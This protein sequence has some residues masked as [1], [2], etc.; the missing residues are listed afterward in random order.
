MYD[1]YIP[2]K[3]HQKL[4]IQSIFPKRKQF[5]KIECSSPETTSSTCD[6]GNE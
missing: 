5:K 3:F 6:V 2:C 4:K 1:K